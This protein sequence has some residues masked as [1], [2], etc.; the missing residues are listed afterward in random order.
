MRYLIPIGCCIVFG[1]CVAFGHLDY[2]RPTTTPRSNSF[3]IIPNHR[4]PEIF[5]VHLQDADV[6][7]AV[8]GEASTTTYLFS[9]YPIP[10]P[11]IPWLPGMLNMRSTHDTPL[12]IELWVIPHGQ[13]VS[14]DLEKITVRTSDETEFRLEDY[15]GPAALIQGQ[16][17]E[18][19]LSHSC[20]LEVAP[21]LRRTEPYV[22]AEPLN[23]GTPMC[24]HLGFALN[25][26]VPIS[27]TLRIDG[28][29]INEVPIAIEPIEFQP[30]TKTGIWGTRPY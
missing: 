12:W 15:E 30:A 6:E 5:Q 19:P 29:T 4:Y 14:L 27:Y 13:L 28:L 3:L 1:G 18:G 2:S 20:S 16:M 8:A 17:K 22:F 26:S 10:L 24:V 11:L 9:P 23:I 7:V 25:V 21:R